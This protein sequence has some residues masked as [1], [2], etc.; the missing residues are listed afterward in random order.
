M[1]TMTRTEL[2]QLLDCVPEKE[3]SRVEV[4]LG[5][6]SDP[7][8]RTI[9]DAPWDDEPLSEEDHRDIVRASEDLEAGRVISHADVCAKF[10]IEP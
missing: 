7:V 10:N 2:H 4:F 9:E 6:L 8:L 5:S 1:T 3:L